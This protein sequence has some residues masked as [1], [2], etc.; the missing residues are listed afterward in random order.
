M[1]KYICIIGSNLA[2]TPITH[3]TLFKF[4]ESM[5]RGVRLS[6]R[7]IVFE[8][9]GDDEAVH[10]ALTEHL[11]QEDELVVFRLSSGR[12]KVNPQHDRQLRDFLDNP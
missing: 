12:W 10:R 3:Q 8:H 2:P 4:F 6:E 9:K 11:H 7:V 5:P 1:P